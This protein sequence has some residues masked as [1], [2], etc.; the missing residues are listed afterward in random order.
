MLTGKDKETGLGLSDDNI[1][2]NVGVIESYCCYVSSDITPH[3]SL[4]SS[5]PVTKPRQA[6]SRS[7]FESNIDISFYGPI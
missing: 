7:G 4:L 2:K 3:S 1:K 5:S 6:R